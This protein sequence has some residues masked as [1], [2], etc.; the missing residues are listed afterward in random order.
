MLDSLKDIDL[1]TSTFLSS[2]PKGY[3]YNESLKPFVQGFLFEIQTAAKVIDKGFNDI[4]GTTVDSYFLDE[5]LREYN[6]P[7][8]IFTD[9]DTAEKKVFAIQMMKTANTLNSVEDYENFM[10]L[11]GFNVKFYH[12]NE[13][14]DGSGFPYTF[15][16]SFTY[17]LG[18]KD[19]ITWLIYIE[20]KNLTQGDY[21]GLGDAFNIDFVESASDLSFPKNILDYLKPY[22]IIFQYIT[23]E[24]KTSLGL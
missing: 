21:N 23:L 19:K 4:L 24:Q 2:L 8:F 3:L 7:N 14:I 16:A 6:L 20:D 1:L 15:P 17:S 11:L 5:E 9:L 18:K 10:A 22:D 12:N 13:T